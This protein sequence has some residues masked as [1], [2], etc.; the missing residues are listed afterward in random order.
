MST[1]LI[2]KHMAAKDIPLFASYLFSEEGQHYHHWEFDV[3]VGD[4]EDPG[5][6]FPMSARRQALYLNSLKIDA[7][8]WFFST[9]KLIECK[10]NAGLGAI[11]QVLGYRKWYEIIFGL[12]PSMLIVCARMPRQI[13][14]LCDINEIA[15]RIVTP[16][17]QFTVDRAIQYVRPRIKKLSILP[18]LASVT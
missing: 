12:A 8:G 10:P 15:Y 18:P 3:I 14:I 2:L 17:D 13:R 9:P 1:P 4:P 6:F 5:P 16:A 11:G 7:I